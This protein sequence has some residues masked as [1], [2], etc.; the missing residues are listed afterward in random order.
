MHI[1]FRDIFL[2]NLREYSGYLPCICLTL[3]VLMIP[4]AL[5][6]IWVVNLSQNIDLRFL[7]KG[8][9]HDKNHDPQMPMLFLDVL[10]FPNQLCERPVV[11]T[12]LAAVFSWGQVFLLS[13]H[14]WLHWDRKLRNDNF[15]VSCGAVTER[16]K[17]CMLSGASSAD[18]AW[19][20]IIASSR[21]TEG[22]WVCDFSEIWELIPQSTRF[23]LLCQ[24]CFHHYYLLL[25]CG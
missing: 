24:L 22:P 6:Q 15:P 19:R 14:W 4:W 13:E 9:G 16:S 25:I 12:S 18:R 8:K 2:G 3:I 11:D 21:D 17:E 20:N 5:I 10:Q 23:W 7:F 1:F